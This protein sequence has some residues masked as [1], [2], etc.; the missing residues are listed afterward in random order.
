M[1]Q[2]NRYSSIIRGIFLSKFKPGAREVDFERED[3]ERFARKLKIRLPKN[4]GD[5][6]YSFR[7]R[8]ALP[9]EIQST[10]GAAETWIIRPAGRAR[11]SDVTK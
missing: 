6:I 1:T 10:A 2:E 4:L 3:I 9:E 8:A 11:N 5:L 7:Y